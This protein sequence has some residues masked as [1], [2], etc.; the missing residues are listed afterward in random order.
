ME[1]SL[2]RKKG[3]FRRRRT[4]RS[5][6]TVAALRDLLKKKHEVSAAV[7]VLI[8]FHNQAS[9]GLHDWVCDG[10]PTICVYRNQIDEW[11]NHARPLKPDFFAKHNCWG[12]SGICTEWAYELSQCFRVCT[13]GISTGL[14]TLK[15]SRKAHCLASILQE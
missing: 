7:V 13:E 1:T 2:N 6:E 9:T 14:R 11:F 15:F 10:I 3:Y 4:A 12:R 5:E 8:K